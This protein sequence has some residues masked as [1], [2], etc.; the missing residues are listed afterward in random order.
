MVR[1]F[2]N[3][4]HWECDLEKRA[5][6]YLTVDMTVSISGEQINMNSVVGMPHGLGVQLPCPSL[7]SSL[8]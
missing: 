3:V 4:M 5:V 1:S 8:H 7:I 2:E 6:K